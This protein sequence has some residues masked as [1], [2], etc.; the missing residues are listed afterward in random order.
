MQKHFV[1]FFSPGSFF[2]EESVRPIASWSV[3]EACSMAAS[4]KERYGATPHSFQFS[5]FQFSTRSRAPNEL[6]SKESARSPTYWLGGTVRTAAEVLSGT[7]PDERILR[8]NV[9]CNGYN[10]V[11]VN[12]NSYRFTSE[13]REGDVLLDWT[14]ERGLVVS[15]EA[16]S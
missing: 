2:V 16:M 12:T 9:E 8:S 3:E 4:I 7:D 1:H 13:F 11:I 10:A 15:R 6:D 14:K 5:T